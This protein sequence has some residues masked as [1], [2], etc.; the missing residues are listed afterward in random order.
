MSPNGCGNPRQGPIRAA[1]PPAE[2]AQPT[3]GLSHN[4]H[5]SHQHTT[6]SP[7][8]SSHPTQHKFTSSVKS[9]AALYT[10]RSGAPCAAA[11]P[12]KRRLFVCLSVSCFSCAIRPQCVRVYCSPCDGSP[13]PP[14]P[15][16]PGPPPARPHATHSSFC[17]L[18]SPHCAA[19]FRLLTP[20]ICTCTLLRP[21]CCQPQSSPVPS[22]RLAP[23][24]TPAPSL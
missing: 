1:G 22:S 2:Q 17:A 23:S 3:G 14:S 18:A 21:T 4:L 10:G 9:N 16:P 12:A 8:S 13:A 7:A 24:H 19:G 6:A 15:H 5:T 20:G 11:L